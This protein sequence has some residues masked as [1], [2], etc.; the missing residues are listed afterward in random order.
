MKKLLILAIVVLAALGLTAAAETLPAG[1][2]Y[3]FVVSQVEVVEAEGKPTLSIYTENRGE[4]PIKAFVIEASMLSEDGLPLL[5]NEATPDGFAN[6]LRFGTLV[7]LIGF[8]NVLEPGKRG[9][10]SETL[11]EK[12]S[13]SKLARAAV[14]YYQYEDG[15]EVYLGES[16]LYWVGSD[17][18]AFAPADP[19]QTNGALNKATWELAGTVPFGM[20]TDSRPLYTYMAGAYGLSSGGNWV[21][22]VSEGSRAEKA[23]IQPGDLVVTIDGIP[24]VENLL[25][26]DLAKAKLAQGQDIELV[27]ERNGEQLTLNVKSE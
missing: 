7:D 26:Y 1:D 3:G 6:E 15:H 13:S 20:L 2:P 5:E 10:T 16:A 22:Q 4:Q 23:G 25:A 9:V 8:S 27:V 14:T 11:P 24:F 18:Q 21:W 19:T 12:L 17:G